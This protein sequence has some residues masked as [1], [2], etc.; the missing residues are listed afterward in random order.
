MNRLA[1]P[2]TPTSVVLP[3]R[4]TSDLDPRFGIVEGFRQPSVMADI[5]AGWDRVVL[6]WADVQPTGPGDFSWLGRTIPQRELSQELSRGV[7]FAGVL[8]FTPTWAAEHPED[9]ARSP[10][11]NLELPDDDQNNYWGRFVYEAVKFYAGRIDEWIVWNEPEFRAGDPGAGGAYTW[12]G[13]D[14]QFAQLMRVAYRAAKR[15]NPHA[16]V[17]FPGTSYWIDQQSQPRREQF[18]ERYLQ[19]L[20]S[21]TEARAEGFYH[22]ALPLNLYLSP[23]DVVR[24]GQYF[25]DIQARYAISKPLWLLE[26]NAMPTDDTRAPCAAQHANDVVHTT[27]DQQAAYAM[28]ALALGAAMGYARISFYKMVDGDACSEPALWGIVRDDGSQRPVADTLRVAVHSFS[29]FDRAQFVPLTRSSATW[30][31]WPGDPASYFPNWQVYQVVFSMRGQRRVTVLWNGD[32][33]A[34]RIAVSN[35]GASAHLVDRNGM[36]RPLQSADGQWLIDLP[37]ATAHYA[38]DPPAYY[39]IGGD[40]VI[41]TQ[42]GVDPSLPALPPVVVPGP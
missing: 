37:P 36:D 30:T 20:Q 25:K 35:V 31:A 22:D 17:A 38:H 15:A 21:D 42:T 40:P 33:A 6:S 24:V 13:T 9:G 19:L 27:L 23:D 5:G 1:R 16:V 34:S 12:L 32:G 41:L 14:E 3:V 26:L 4:A 8:Q 28:Q 2:P 7:T 18:Y 29:G 10:P 11:R 39:Y